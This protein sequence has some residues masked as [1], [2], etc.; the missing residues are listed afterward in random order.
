MTCRTVMTDKFIFLATRPMSSAKLGKDELLS[1]LAEWNIQTETLE[2][3][4]VG[5][6]K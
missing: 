3:P 6:G 4:Q 5:S 2:H 1:K